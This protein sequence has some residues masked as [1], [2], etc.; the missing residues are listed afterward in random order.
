MSNFC[1]T[2]GNEE[3]WKES[4]EVMKRINDESYRIRKSTRQPR[5]M[6]FKR[7][8][9]FALYRN[10]V[11]SDE[12]HIARKQPLMNDEWSKEVGMAQY[13]TKHNDKSR[14]N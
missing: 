5:E 4:F 6:Q 2:R 3:G 9:S 14:K 11:H 8:W 1:I 10:I 7:P 12:T 13:S